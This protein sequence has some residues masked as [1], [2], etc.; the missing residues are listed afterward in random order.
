VAQDGPQI[1]LLLLCDVEL[2]G[3]ASV[4]VGWNTELTEKFFSA[5]WV[6]FVLKLKALS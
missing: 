3:S 2:L 4:G 6:S 5:V 1:Y